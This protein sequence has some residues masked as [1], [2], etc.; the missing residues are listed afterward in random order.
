MTGPIGVNPNSSSIFGFFSSRRQES[1]PANDRTATL[2]ST[3]IKAIFKPNGFNTAAGDI[4]YELKFRNRDIQAKIDAFKKRHPDKVSQLQKSSW[5]DKIKEEGSKMRTVVDAQGASWESFREEARQL[6]EEVVEL[7]AKELGIP[8]PDWKNEGTRGY[9][10]D[11]DN[12][13]VPKPQTKEINQ[14]LIKILADTCWYYMFGGLSGTQADLEVYLPHPGFSRATELNMSPESAPQFTRLELEMGLLEVFRGFDN[15]ADWESFIEDFIE[16]M[17]EMQVEIE[18][19]RQN[20]ETFESA[21]Q[22]GTLRQAY[23]N[24]FLQG[25]EEPRTQVRTYDVAQKLDISELHQMIFSPDELQKARYQYTAP[26]LMIISELMDKNNKLI[27]S[28]KS[29]LT[30]TVANTTLIQE[31][32]K[33][34]LANASYAALRNALFSESYSTQSAMITVGG[35]KAGQRE[36][37]HIEESI[38]SMSSAIEKN[39][40]LFYIMPKPKYAK[41]TYTTLA[42]SALENFG[43]AIGTMEEQSETTPVRFESSLIKASKYLERSTFF[44]SQAVDSIPEEIGE[45]HQLSKEMVATCMEL[46]KCK[47][48]KLTFIMAEQLILEALDP[49]KKTEKFSKNLEEFFNKFKM[50]GEYYGQE[51]L[52]KELYEAAMAYFCANVLEELPHEE[53]GNVFSSHPNF[54]V[55]IM[56]LCGFPSVISPNPSSRDRALIP[57][58][59]KRPKLGEVIQSQNAIVLE[60]LELNSPQ[61]INL[62]LK[63][64]SIIIQTVISSGI[65]KGLMVP[66][67]NIYD[68]SLVSMWASADEECKRRM[69]PNSSTSREA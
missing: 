18:S 62:F 56:G 25:V 23:M 46:E 7:A 42:M 15:P 20:I 12:V 30:S 29:Q 26:R 63:Q 52:P 11:I 67:S 17:P 16:S 5:K 39:R 57:L 50:D 8:T 69:V 28:K 6:Q 47:R 60:E 10:S 51:I 31:I 55:A 64:V 2:K 19:I 32:S 21:I 37:R 43:K 58:L 36:K 53:D 22:E 27:K 41:I 35:A 9:Q 49:D 65:E 4:W 38:E 66:P 68:C 1:T 33:L 59:E 3:I 44:I 24:V 48:G 13:I 61:Q 54:D 40:E 34:E 45:L 14:M